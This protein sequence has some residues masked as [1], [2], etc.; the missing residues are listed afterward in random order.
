MKALFTTPTP[1]NKEEITS[2]MVFMRKRKILATPTEHSYS[3]G[4]VPSHH[5]APSEVQVTPLEVVDVQ[6]CEAESSKKPNLWDPNLDTSSYLEENL[7][8]IKEKE[9]LMAHDE[10]HLF[11]EAMRLFGQAH[12]TSCLAISKLKDR[13]VAEDIRVRETSKLHKEVERL[14]KELQLSKTSKKET[15]KHLAATTKTAVAE[16]EKFLAEVAKLKEELS[17]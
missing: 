9:K 13:V 14:Q 16:K 6:E 10:S 7:L 8:P 5:V 2:G 1:T 15:K 17:S 3:V 11:C 4:R 12:A